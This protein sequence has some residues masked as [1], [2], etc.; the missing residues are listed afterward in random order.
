MTVSLETSVANLGGCLADESGSGHAVESTRF[1]HEA[2]LYDTDDE[3]AATTHGFVDDGL[4][5]GDLI[6]ARVDS[7]TRAVLDETL[8]PAGVEHVARDCTNPAAALHETH[9]MVTQALTPGDA[10]RIRILGTPPTA[11]TWDWMRYEAAINH[12]LDALPVS[13][14]CLYDRR[15]TSAADL[16]DVGRT[17]PHVKDTHCRCRRPAYQRPE[18]FLDARD[19]RPDPLERT[20][21]Q[22]TLTDP[23]PEDL[24]DAIERLAEGRTS[25]ADRN[26]IDDLRIA[27]ATVAKNARRHTTAP[28]HVNGWAREGRLVITVRDHGP[29]IAS[30]FPGLIPSDLLADADRADS[31]HLITQTI[32]RAAFVNQPDGLL[33]R[34]VQDT[35]AT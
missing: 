17:H 33:V 26:A 10:R 25:K 22:L 6:I 13:S 7:R 32:T 9:R 5:D 1:R 12:V 24:H 23:E 16:D 8:D 18:A 27:A 3:L 14:L 15:T 29:G 19:R 4:R 30:P 28:F 11:N 20:A 34:L 31:L 35:R 2:F 21:P